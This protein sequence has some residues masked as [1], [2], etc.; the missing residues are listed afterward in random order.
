MERS[1]L[2]EPAFGIS[3]VIPTQVETESVY[4]VSSP[5]TLIPPYTSAPSYTFVLPYT[6]SC[7]ARWHAH[8]GSPH[9]TEMVVGSH[10]IGWLVPFENVRAGPVG[11]MTAPDKPTRRHGQSGVGLLD[12]TD[13]GVGWVTAAAGV[14]NVG[15]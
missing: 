8:F 9:V 13:S 15:V 7:P 6:L 5:C 3:Q 4:F 12:P 14:P 1:S 11:T 2:N 10:C